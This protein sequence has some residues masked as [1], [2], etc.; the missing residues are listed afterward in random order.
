MGG[1]VI[2]QKMILVIMTILFP[3]NFICCTS[4]KYEWV[5]ENN[6]WYYISKDDGSKNTGWINDQG[7]W[8]YLNNE[9]IMQTGW[10]YDKGNWYYLYGNGI[11]AHDTTIGEFYV[12]SNGAWSNQIPNHS[13]VN[14]NIEVLYWKTIPVIIDSIVLGRFGTAEIK[15][16]SEEYNLS[17]V[18][19]QE[20]G[21]Y[22]A[23]LAHMGI[24]KKGDI[25]LF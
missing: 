14:S 19:F 13:E 21:S 9:G 23:E 1:I 10:L 20:K 17:G 12:N 25:K 24:I 15:V 16:R 6:K 4:S 3:L 7:N 22:Y 2:K 18:F 5:S 8:Y 11:M